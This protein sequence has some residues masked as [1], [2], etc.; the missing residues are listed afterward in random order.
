MGIV[1]LQENDRCSDP[2]LRHAL[3]YLAA[4]GLLHGINEWLDMFQGMGVFPSQPGLLP[5]WSALR[6]VVLT[7]SFLPLATF[8]ALLLAPNERYRRL[9]LLVPLILA[10]IWAYGLLIL[11]SHYSSTGRIWDVVDAW[12]RYIAAIPAALL[13]CAGL[14][15]QQR[16]FRLAGMAQFGRDALWA[17]IAFAWYGLIGQIFTKPSPL[18]PSTYLNTN[19]FLHLFGFPVQLLRALAA[20][21][22][23]VFVLRFLRS[24]EVENQRK[25]A[26]LQAARLEE[27]QRRQELRG[28]LL[29]RVVAAQE[30]ERQRVARDLHDA[31]GQSLTALG[32]GLRGVATMLRQDVDKAAQN[33]Q[34]LEGMVDGALLE[35]QR[36]IADLRPTHLDDLG[37]PAALRWYCSEIQN[38]LPIQV[39][40]EIEGET[41]EIPAEVSLTV[42]RVAQEALTNVIKH[43]EASH[44]VVRLYF[45]TS[46]VTLQV[47]DDGCGFDSKAL[48]ITNRSSWG[49]IGMQERASLL[50]GNVIIESNPGEGTRV[51]VTIPYNQELKEE[52]DGNPFGIGG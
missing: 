42:F 41:R 33:L 3:F 13:A 32:L 4:F 46:A 27:A 19:L 45:Q 15:H 50:G 44:A 28:E 6:A 22:V 43:S 11:N 24:F 10:G 14:I 49:L 18:P 16:Q 26:E 36:L 31:T 47:E 39:S 5:L 52:K 7:F 21:V 8:G 2:R 23:A 17:S 51:Q 20:L 48:A 12:T 37:L 29:R 35:L 25:I 40:V 38:H 1:I 34:R 30:A 9:A